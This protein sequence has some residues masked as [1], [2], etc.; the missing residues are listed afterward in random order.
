MKLLRLLL[1]PGVVLVLVGVAYVN[2]ATETPGTRMTVAG[3]KLLDSLSDEQ[4]AKPTF[5]FDAKERTKVHFVP[6]E[7]KTTKKPTRKGLRLEEMNADQKKAALELLKA[8]TSA[9]GYTAATTI[10]G[11]ESILADLEKGSG[12]VRNSEWYFFT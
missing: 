2:Q 12:P 9:D 4:K 1:V 3:Q 10:M 6:L 8:G 11:L 5:A 7:A